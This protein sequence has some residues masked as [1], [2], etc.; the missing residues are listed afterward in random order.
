M[1]NADGRF[2]LLKSAAGDGKK[3]EEICQLSVG[4]LLSYVSTSVTHTL[5]I[6][7]TE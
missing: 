6:E 5:H 2:K 7:L 3:D 1:L 4:S